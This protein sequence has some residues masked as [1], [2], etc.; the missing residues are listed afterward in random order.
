L[1]LSQ[2]AD[3]FNEIQANDLYHRVSKKIKKGIFQIPIQITLFQVPYSNNVL[4]YPEDYLD[5]SKWDDWYGL[6]I[7]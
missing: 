1:S 3:E 7:I 5:E 2:I 6:D 4:D